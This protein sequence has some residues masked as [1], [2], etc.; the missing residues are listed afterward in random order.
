LVLFVDVINIH[1]IDKNSDAVQERLNMVI[2][3]F[4]T[5]LSNYSLIINTEKSKAILSWGISIVYSII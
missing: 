4:E 5:W 1:I 2:K 3:Q